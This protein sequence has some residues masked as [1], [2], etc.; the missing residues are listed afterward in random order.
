MAWAAAWSAQNTDKYLSFYADDFKT[1]GGET[2]AAWEA[3]RRERLSK[4]KFISVGVGRLGASFTDSDHVVV[5][6]HQSYR[7]GRF[8]ATTSKTLRMVKSGGK[9]LIQEERT[10]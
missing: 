3:V 7:S 9:W 2:R 5:K 6:F 1:P 10:R 8:K 4:P